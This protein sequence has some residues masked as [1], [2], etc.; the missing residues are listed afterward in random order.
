[1]TNSLTDIP[2]YTAYLWPIIEQLR[3][4]G[5]SMTIEEMVD[6]VSSSM[7]LSDD[8][9]EVP[10]GPSGYTEVGYRMAWARTYLKK[11]G[12]LENSARGVWRLTAQGMTIGAN[13]VASIPKQVAKDAAKARKGRPSQASIADEAPSLP[14]SPE[15]ESLWTDRLLSVLMKMHP[16]AF[17]RLCQRVLRESGFVKVEVTGRSGDGGIDGT[18]VLRVNLL[19]F[20]V[21]FQCKRYAGSVGSGVVRDFRGAMV[22]RADKGLVITTGN[23]TADARREA[24]R[25]GAPAIDL[26]DGPALCELLKDL[27]IGV[28]VQMV[29]RVNVVD[30]LFDTL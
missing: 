30:E 20:H 11:A 12:V 29:E 28:E 9:R 23:F 15:D 13:D 21:L 14:N 24:V 26:I 3:A 16:A 5:S 27:R 18:G 4:H 8:Q 25:D 1:M 22:G 6:A 19:S 17:E 10:H 7:N 2:P